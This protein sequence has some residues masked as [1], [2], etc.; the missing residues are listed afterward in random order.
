MILVVG[1]TGNIGSE[2]LRQL[3]AAKSPTS[4]PVRALVRSPEKAGDLPAG[5]ELV[6][7]DLGDPATFEP[8]LE[9][10]D[11]IFVCLNP[12]PDLVLLHKN[13]F[14]LAKRHKVKHIV[15]VSVL[16]AAA[17]SPVQ[18][19]RWHHEADE[20]LKASGI[21]WTILQ[22]T[23]F[24]QNLAG[25]A[26]LIAAQGIIPVP[27]GN[28]KAAVLDLRDIASVAVKILAKREQHAGKTYV[29]TGAYALSFADM[30]REI[31]SVLGQRCEHKDVTPAE[32]EQGMK[33]MGIPDFF[34]AD[35]LT[36]YAGMKAGWMAD[37]SDHVSLVGQR[38]PRSFGEFVRDNA[39]VFG[40]KQPS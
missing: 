12:S 29:L 34:V 5:F 31:W 18:I 30:A 36:L 21:A 28:G 23:F 16:G 24:M 7:G 27:T 8:A 2:L 37:V 35:M 9:G 20:A 32:A 17:D 38:S 26:P 15:K 4:E 39:Q 6:K 1:S 19:A 11:A 22:P 13:L 33:A 3:A 10:V 40:V 14:T 25:F